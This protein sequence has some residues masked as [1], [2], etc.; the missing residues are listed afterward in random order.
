M[1][2]S[3]KLNLP[4][5]T[6]IQATSYK[7]KIYKKTPSQFLYWLFFV[8]A[9]VFV[10]TAL[11]ALWPL[12]VKAEISK[13]VLSVD[14]LYSEIDVNNIYETRVFYQG[15]FITD[16][17]DESGYDWLRTGDTYKMYSMPFFK[18]DH[19]FLYAV[20]FAT[21]TTAYFE[22][23]LKSVENTFSFIHSAYAQLYFSEAGDGSTYH[24]SSDN[25]DTTHDAVTSS[26]FLTTIRVESGKSSAGYT[27]ISRAFLPFDTSSLADDATIATASIFL[28]ESSTVNQ[29]DDGDDWINIVQTTEA[30]EGNPAEVDYDQCGAVN[31]PIEG[32]TRVDFSAIVSAGYTEF[33][34]NTTGLTWIDKT[35][36]TQIGMR[37][38]H[39]AIDSPYGGAFNSSNRY[40]AFSSLEAG[41][42]KDPYL[43]ITLVSTTTPPATTTP[44]VSIPCDTDNF[45]S[46]ISVISTCGEV[47]GNSTTAPES[48]T[49]TYYYSPFLL[50]LFISIIIWTSLI[51]ILIFLVK[52]MK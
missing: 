13:D 41:T 2:K 4:L 26:D 37:E 45:L 15:N 31:D 43:Q 14:V 48:T 28:Y 50:F 6:T 29:D 22:E 32:S 9:W 12:T 7:K 38:G 46:D 19:D 34:L 40:M 17:Y 36:I 52:I 25:W 42:D 49:Y 30:S 10:F 44:P 33:A 47:W 35:G 5:G 18:D 8:L 39:D 20:D 3:V 24:F 27:V 11:L 21:T 1:N 23:N 16:N 51:A